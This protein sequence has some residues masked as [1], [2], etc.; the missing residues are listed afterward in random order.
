MASP[1]SEQP[2]K[3]PKT[4]RQEELTSDDLEK[5]VGGLKK[6]VGVSGPPRSGLTADPCEG[7]E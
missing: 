2:P 6:N 3:T 7:G 1:K 4:T 5:V